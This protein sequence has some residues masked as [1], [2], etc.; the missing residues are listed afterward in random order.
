MSHLTRF[1]QKEFRG[2][3]C[4]LDSGGSGFNP[5]HLQFRS[6]DDEKYERPAPDLLPIILHNADQWSDIKH[7]CMF[8]ERNNSINYISTSFSVPNQF[9]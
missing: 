2:R 8:M 4:A 6:S 3:A 1:N 7:P 5:C 9:F